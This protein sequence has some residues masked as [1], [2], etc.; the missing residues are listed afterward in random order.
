M[1]GDG[2]KL[3]GAD[4]ELVPLGYKYAARRRS[5]HHR[6]LSHLISSM[7]VLAVAALL[8]AAALATEVLI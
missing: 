3:F 6:H 2:E 5:N 7:K 4:L 1:R 8:V